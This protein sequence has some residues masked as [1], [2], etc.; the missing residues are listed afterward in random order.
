MNMVQWNPWRDIDDLFSRIGSVPGEQ[1][2]RSEWVPPIDIVETET[3]YQLEVDIP[4]VPADQVEVAFE[5]RVLTISGERRPDP[6]RSTEAGSGVK[7]LRVERQFGK[8]TRSFRLPE[9]SDED[10]ITATARDGVLTVS[11]ARK[12]RSRAR[13]IQVQVEV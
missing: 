10:G 9:D 11:I 1:L 4:A 7:R 13:S 6:D 2:D 12:T 8:F 5:D 3:A